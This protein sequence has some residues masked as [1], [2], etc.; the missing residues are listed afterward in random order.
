MQNL[1]ERTNDKF[2]FILDEWDSIFYKTFMNDED[3][4]AYLEFL[5]GLLK[6][7]PYVELAYMT[8]VL[9]ILQYSNGSELNMFREYN[10]MNDMIYESYFGFTE[11]EVRELCEH[12][13]D[14]SYE[15]LKY[16]YD[17]YHLSDGSS[18]FNPRSVNNALS[19]GVCQNY[20]TETGPM[21]EI[22]NCI[23]Y[24][25]EA[26]REDVVKMV[27]EIP[28]RADLEGYNAAQLQLD[29]RD[30]ILSSMV[31]YGFL[32][33][34]N[35]FLTIPNHELMIKFQ[36]VLKEEYMGGV[37]EIVRQSNEIL[38]A[39]MDGDADKVAEMIEIAHDKEI[40]FLQYNN[41]NSMSCV[42]TL[43]YLS[44]RNDYEITREDKSGKGYVD[45]L[46]TPKISGYPA[47]ILELKYDK[48]A[49]EAIKQI[50]DK[51]YIEKI[52]YAEECLFVGINYAKK[53]KKHTCLIE[54]ITHKI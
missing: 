30:E 13:K 7:Q 10:F 6:D 38:K 39:T 53:D 28:V 45:F 43:C 50:K 48:T 5:K 1:F 31:I 24:N 33:Y 19:D 12:S 42:I 32:S 18:L 46:F 51:N 26:V 23:K 22:S 49:E 27:S 52:N 25:V 29:T 54:K 14:V 40:P 34:H 2:I 21:H 37:S 8:G 4:K 17:G 47:I 11:N 15:E 9:P 36:N 35:G 3:K 44:A 16:W 20:W 41:E